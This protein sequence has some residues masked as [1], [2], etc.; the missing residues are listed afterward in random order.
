MNLFETLS[1]DLKPDNQAVKKIETDTLFK[2][3]EA[4]QE[5]EVT[6]NGSLTTEIQA[7]GIGVG[8]DEVFEV[9]IDRKTIEWHY[10][11][12]EE[13]NEYIRELEEW[14]NDKS[15]LRDMMIDNIH[16]V[17]RLAE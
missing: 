7:D 1:K 17:K 9:T 13:P 4:I 10:F 5:F 8:I 11:N 2:C 16:K 3:L 6:F 12:G 15:F 14:K